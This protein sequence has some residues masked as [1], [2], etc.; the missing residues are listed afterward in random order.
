M[1]YTGIDKRCYIAE[2]SMRKLYEHNDRLCK[3]RSRLEKGSDW[4]DEREDV[5]FVK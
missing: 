4:S 5:V 2:R 3:V 1:R